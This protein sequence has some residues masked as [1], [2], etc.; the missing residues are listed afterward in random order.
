MKEGI[1]GRRLR[2][3]REELSITQTDLALMLDV[4]PSTIATYETKNR[5]PEYRI[6]VK[7]AQFFGVSTDYLLGLS[8]YRRGIPE[9]LEQEWPD[10]I[11]VLRRASRQM[12]PEEKQFI[13]RMLQAYMKS[14][15][16]RKKS[17]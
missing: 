14:S 17:K 9:P 6:L 11:K 16:E 12:T 10:G 1:F 7:I 13:V 15:R 3:L 4:A 5:V 2:Q 8:D